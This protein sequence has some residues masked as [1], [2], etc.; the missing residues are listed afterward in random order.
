[1]NEIAKLDP[2]KA[3]GKYLYS[4]SEIAVAEKPHKSSIPIHPKNK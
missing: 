4:C 1:M 2:I 3:I